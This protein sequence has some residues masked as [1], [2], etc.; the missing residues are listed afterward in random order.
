MLRFKLNH[1]SKMAPWC[2]KERKITEFVDMEDIVKKHLKNLLKIAHGVLD[3]MSVL[4]Q[5]ACY[6]LVHKLLWFCF[7]GH[8]LFSAL[9]VDSWWRHHFS[10]YWPFVRRIH[11][12][13]VNSPHKGQWHGALMFS[14]NCVWINSWVNNCEAGDLRLY[15]AQFDVIVM[16]VFQ[17]HTIRFIVIADI[18]IRH[19]L[20]I[21][22]T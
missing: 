3:G 12:S 17:S 1:V 22:S 14:L 13:P 7:Q 16:Y 21:T 8:L 11:R 18:R 6:L 2:F 15:R 9:V 20:V 4:V 19:G 5:L 10:R